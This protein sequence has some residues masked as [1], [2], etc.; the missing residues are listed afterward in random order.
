MIET[1]QRLLRNILAFVALLCVA[2]PAMAQC[3]PSGSTSGA[4]LPA[5]SPFTTPTNQT[6]TVT[7]RNTGNAVCALQLS[8]LSPAVPASMIGPG[9]PTLTY[10]IESSSGAQTLVSTAA[11]PTAANTL[12]FSVPAAVGGVAGQTVVS[13]RVR[14]NASQVVPAGSYVDTRVTAQIFDVTTAGTLRLRLF[15][16]FRVAATVLSVCQLA[17]PS[18][19]SMNFTA[20]IVRG[21][22][23]GAVQTSNLVAT[24]TARTRVRLTAGALTRSAA[25]TPVA[26]FDTIINTRATASLGGVSVVHQTTGAAVTST[27]SAAQSSGTSGVVAVGV[28]LINGQTV[29]A[30][31][32]GSV[33]TISIDPS[34]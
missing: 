31:S 32:Y 14:A 26:G 33:L 17:A 23:V 8:F 3:T 12:A 15:G 27:T 4:T 13:F 34:F 11:V 6:A 22:P 2:A 21:R 10:T 29:Q 24:C 18:V 25:V 7:V 28:N 16:T 19:A 30:G 9:T 5:Y 1:I 20:D